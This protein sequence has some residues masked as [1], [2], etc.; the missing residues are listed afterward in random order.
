MNIDGIKRAPAR[1]MNV[2]SMAVHLAVVVDDDALAE[3]GADADDHERAARAGLPVVDV[4]VVDQAVEVPLG[5][6]EADR[7]VGDRGGG[8]LHRE[9]SFCAGGALVEQA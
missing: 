5:A 9:S 2:F 8:E 6:D 1:C 3:H 4:N 7:E